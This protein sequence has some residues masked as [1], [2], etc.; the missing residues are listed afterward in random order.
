MPA[1]ASQDMICCACC[2]K[3][4]MARSKT[5]RKYCS[6]Q[7]A[8]IGRSVNPPNCK[9]Q[10]SRA[11]RTGFIVVRSV[12]DGVF[13]PLQPVIGKPY[14]AQ[15]WDRAGGYPEFCAIEIGGK[16][17]V[18]RPGEYQEIAEGMA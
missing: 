16:L 1:T 6:T 10:H 14:L 9:K 2:G 17:I 11:R 12:I 7:C 18:L 3:P 15:I 8:G 5:H 4:F 13:L